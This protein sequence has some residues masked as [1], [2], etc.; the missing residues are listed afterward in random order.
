M[1]NIMTDTQTTL[2][3]ASIN[4]WP[5]W[6]VLTY[7]Y[8]TYT[9]HNTPRVRE[10]WVCVCVCLLS[11]IVYACE[12]NIATNCHVC[13]EVSTGINGRLGRHKCIAKSMWREMS[14]GV[15]QLRHAELYVTYAQKIPKPQKLSGPPKHTWFIFVS[16][17][18]GLHQT[19]TVNCTNILHIFP[20]QLNA[21]VSPNTIS[22]FE[23]K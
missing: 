21:H 2:P 4:S 13:Q 3:T 14:R 17:S 12:C 15:S 7:L 16:T 19:D 1:S 22:V 5:H 18:W 20:R 8:R 10:H 6:C 9:A 11:T 23:S